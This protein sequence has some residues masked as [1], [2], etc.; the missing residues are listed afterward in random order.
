MANYLDRDVELDR[1][2]LLEVIDGPKDGYL[3][4]IRVDGRR[5]GSICNDTCWIPINTILRIMV[6]MT[7]IN[8]CVHMHT[9]DIAIMLGDIGNKPHL[10]KVTIQGASIS[11]CSK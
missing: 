11:L 7:E 4:R 8:V 9:D 2:G 3:Y 10:K 6:V 1:D 5:Y